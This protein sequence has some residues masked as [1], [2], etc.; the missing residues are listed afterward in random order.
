MPK[1]T[2]GRLI[3]HDVLFWSKEIERR[4]PS[5]DLPA[6][7]EGLIRSKAQL[8]AVLR[9]D[10]L[11]KLVHRLLVRVLTAHGETTPVSQLSEWI[12]FRDVG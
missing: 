9:E 7:W 3:A 2:S 11:D 6:L 12:E 4:T 1:T 5:A 10:Q 8:L